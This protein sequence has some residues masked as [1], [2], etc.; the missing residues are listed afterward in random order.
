MKRRNILLLFAL[1]IMFCLSGC[2]DGEDELANANPDTTPTSIPILNIT[3]T[4]VPTSPSLKPTAT[5]APTPTSTPTSELSIIIPNTATPT[6]TATN[7]AKP[8]PTNSASTSPAAGNGDV[9]I[10][11]VN[12]TIYIVV[13][14]KLNVRQGPGTTFEKIGSLFNGASVKRTGICD[15]GWVRIVYNGKEG[16]VHSDY[17]TDKDPSVTTVP[18]PT[19]EPT[20]TPVPTD[21]PP[22]IPIDTPKVTLAPTNP[23]ANPTS[24]PTDKPSSNT[25]VPTKAGEVL[26]PS[27]VYT[28][29]LVNKAGND[30][31]YVIANAKTGAIIYSENPDYKTS[32]ASLTKM[33][34]AII[35]MENLPSSGF[36][37][38]IKSTDKSL[39]TYNRDNEMTVLVKYGVPVDTEYTLEQWL[40]IMLIYSAADAAETLAVAVAGDLESFVAKMNAKA[41]ELGMTNTH[42]DNVVGGDATSGNYFENYSTAADLVKLVQAFNQYDELVEIAGTGSF[43]LEESG[44]VPA[45]T[46]NNWNGILGES[47]DDFLISGT[48]T[49]YTSDAGYCS[50]I[51][52]TSFNGCDDVIV[53]YLAGLDT[54]ARDEEILEMLKYVYKND[55]SKLR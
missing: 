16:F 47:D 40:N 53:I 21:F 2:G 42:F 33:M 23:V 36:G 25:P 19:P 54:Q 29:D 30:G 43:D 28:G 7:T 18:T 44:S 34:T 14:D 3:D 12:D 22:V 27:L 8:S 32:I 1:C 41:I 55:K 10:T 13:D 35:V 39:T 4:P 37:T 46:L 31:A 51:T 11:E 6:P 48:K 38:V 50:A 49:G 20:K 17:I 45:K 9:K 5:N 52:A 15:N 26:A 24:K